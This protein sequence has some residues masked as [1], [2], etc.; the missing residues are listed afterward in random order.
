MQFIVFIFLC[1][2]L[3][4][5]LYMLSQ[6]FSNRVIYQEFS[7]PDFPESFQQIHI[8][9]ISDIHRRR[10]SE[11]I[12]REVKGKADI[13]IIGGDLLEKGVPLKRVEEN[14]K[15]LRKLG[16]IFFVLG[17]NDYEIES[18]LLQF[19][20]G[21]NGAEILN[22]TVKV[23]R[24]DE[25]ETIVLIGVEDLSMEKARLE[26]AMQDAGQEGFR[27]LISHN[28][29]IAI[30]VREE[31]NISLILSGHTHGGQIRILGFG[32]YELGGTKKVG[33]ST[34]LVSNG[35]GTTGLPLR[36]GAKAETHLITLKKQ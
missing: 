35:Y 12:I 27:I 1:L 20:L 14:I 22:N 26:S 30:K 4:L 18:H 25:G 7:F 33:K 5:F 9:F 3:G 17:N 2:S 10:V 15:K 29:D 24:S 32:P 21:Q 36:L 13:V 28:P 6:A 8:F 34:V 11:D 31:H 23:I 19:I 16:P